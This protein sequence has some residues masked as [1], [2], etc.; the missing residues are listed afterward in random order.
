MASYLNL[1]APYL[2]ESVSDE[3]RVN[4]IG[5]LCKK[6]KGYIWAKMEVSKT[7]TQILILLMMIFRSLTL[8]FQVAEL[9]I[10]PGET[11]RLSLTFENTIK[12]RKRKK[13][14]KCALISLC[15]QLDFR[16]E[17]TIS[18][19]FFGS[20]SVTMAV[21]SQVNINYSKQNGLF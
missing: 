16:A 8:F 17:S 2:R 19:G 15:Q 5:Y 21:K 20:K 18:S 11:V 4:L 3:E 1:D 12:K 7:F 13:Q 9:G 14:P 6:P 10:L